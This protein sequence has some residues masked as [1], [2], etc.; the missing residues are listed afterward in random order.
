MKEFIEICKKN[1]KTMHIFDKFLIFIQALWLLLMVFIGASEGTGNFLSRF[2]NWPCI[3]AMLIIWALLLKLYTES[4]AILW[5]YY[6]W[7]ERRKKGGS[8]S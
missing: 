7:K 2:S 1:W 5:K 6:N 3:V 4:H 8:G